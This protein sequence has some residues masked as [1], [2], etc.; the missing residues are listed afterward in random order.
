[1]I[2]IA[3]SI[4]SAD[5]AKMGD[6]LKGIKNADFVHCDVMD[7]HFVPNISFG[8]K[9]VKDIRKITNLI[10]DVHLMIENPEKYLDAFIDAGSDY[11]VIHLESTTKVDFCLDK[12][13]NAGKKCGIAV[14]PDTPV[15]K[16]KAYLKKCDLALLMSV[17]PGFSGQKFIERSFD[18]LAELKRLRDKENKHCIIEIDGGIGEDNIAAVF[19]GGAEIAVAGNAV[20]GFSDPAERID[21]LKK[22]CGN[23]K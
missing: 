10:L 17:Y 14:S 12:I 18:R 23:N 3:P 15:E 22:I 1:M 11:I 6:A 9:M 2:K 4:L 20:F 7:G 8:P 16:L 19:T 13:K 5:F 21:H